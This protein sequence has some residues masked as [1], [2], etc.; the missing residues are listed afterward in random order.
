MTT[1]NVRA[2]RHF[3]ELRAAP[4]ADAEIRR[5]GIAVLRVLEREA[6]ELFGDF[7]VE[8]MGDGTETAQP[9]HSKV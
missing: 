5:L 8:P 3:I 6:P 2:W 1:A 4:T 9:S 7:V